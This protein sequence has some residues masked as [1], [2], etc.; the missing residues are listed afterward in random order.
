LFSQ[1]PESARSRRWF[2]PALRVWDLRSGQLERILN[3]S[4]EVNAIGS[5]P[6]A[7]ERCRPR[8]TVHDAGPQPGGGQSSTVYRVLKAAGLLQD[9]FSRASRKGSV[10]NKER[11]FAAG[12]ESGSNSRLTRNRLIS[13]RFAAADVTDLYQAFSQPTGPRRLW[14]SL[15]AVVWQRSS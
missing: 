8:K 4:G 12:V 15:S 5:P 7:A 1:I 3:A 14:I 6:T 2:P 10:K 13:D 9:R 11:S